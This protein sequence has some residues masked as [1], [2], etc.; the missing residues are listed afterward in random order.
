MVVNTP[1]KYGFGYLKT[2]PDINRLFLCI[3]IHR[4]LLIPFKQIDKI[5]Y[6]VVFE[7]NIN[8]SSSKITFTDFIGES[9]TPIEFAEIEHIKHKFPNCI[10]AINQG[11]NFARGQVTIFLNLT[12][13]TNVSEN[14]FT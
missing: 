7:C 12:G 8:T 10:W 3:F 4:D 2:K 1:P 6:V 14:N 11:L 13:Q 5:Y 9:D